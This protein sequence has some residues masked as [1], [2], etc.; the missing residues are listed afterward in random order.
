VSA[1]SVRLLTSWSY[2]NFQWLVLIKNL[3]D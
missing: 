1:S 3:I 2:R